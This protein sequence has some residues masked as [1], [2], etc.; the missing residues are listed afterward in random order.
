[1]NS[2]PH[3]DRMIAWLRD[4]FA[5]RPEWLPRELELAALR[6]GIDWTLWHNAPPVLEAGLRLAEV[7]PWPG[8]TTKA[9]MFDDTSSEIRSFQETPDAKP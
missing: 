6:D 1:M 2:N 3:V 5:E 7:Q 8:F 9:Y 4:R